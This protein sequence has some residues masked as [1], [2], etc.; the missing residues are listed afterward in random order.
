MWNVI[1]AEGGSFH[2]IFTELTEHFIET[3]GCGAQSPRLFGARCCWGNMEITVRKGGEPPL[4]QQE[5]CLDAPVVNPN[6]GHF[7]LPYVVSSVMCCTCA[8]RRR[9]AVTCGELIRLVSVLATPWLKQ[10]V[11]IV[12]KAACVLTQGIVFIQL[13]WHSPLYFTAISTHWAPYILL[14]DT[15]SPVLN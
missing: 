10:F 6:G 2:T 4:H 3:A 1:T 13:K 9:L 5:A 12:M 11:F 7:S 8:S 14:T 15:G